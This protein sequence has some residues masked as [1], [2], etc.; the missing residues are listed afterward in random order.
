AH[1]RRG[2]ALRRLNSVLEA[3]VALS[4]GTALDPLNNLIVDSLTEASQ[5]LFKDFPLKRLE[6]LGLERDRFTVLTVVGQELASAGHPR[7]ASKVLTRALN[8]HSPSLRL[9]ES[10]LSALASVHYLLGEYQ[11]ATLYYEKQL[12]I[13]SQQ[14]GPLADV[15]DNI[16]TSAELAGNYLLAV[17]HRKHRLKFLEGAAEADERLKIACL[18]CSASQA[19][20]AL[21]Q[22]DIVDQLLNAIAEGD[23]SRIATGIRI[24]RGIAY[25]SMVRKLEFE[26]QQKRQ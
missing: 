12:D 14:G 20:A 2:E 6:G 22:C 17:S 25:S 23:R 16:A 26:E 11:K 3:V 5:Q 9:R 24:G 8:L 15:H 21:E 13:R 18:C 7:E 19:D 10:A 1:Y 4:E